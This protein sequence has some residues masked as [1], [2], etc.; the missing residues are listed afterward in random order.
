M[1]KCLILFAVLLLTLGLAVLSKTNSEIT[2]ESATAV[3]VDYKN[4]K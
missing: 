4:N 1:R 3:S 2:K